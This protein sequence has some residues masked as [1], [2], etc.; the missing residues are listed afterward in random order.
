MIILSLAFPSR[1]LSLSDPPIRR[2]LR[3]Y[4]FALS[5]GLSSHQR[6]AEFYPRLKA[7][8]ADLSRDNQI[9]VFNGQIYYVINR[10]LLMLIKKTLIFWKGLLPLKQK[11]KKLRKN[12]K[13]NT[14][15]GFPFC[16]QVDS[17]NDVRNDSRRRPPPVRKGDFQFEI[18]WHIS[19]TFFFLLRSLQVP[20]DPFVP[21]KTF[22]IL[23]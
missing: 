16:V 5:P 3:Q 19:E 12:K 17:L 11:G 4:F 7:A 21:L 13:S 6:F 14:Y 9:L 23:N 2:L 15:K 8:K 20:P 1:R 22:F 10:N 18:Y